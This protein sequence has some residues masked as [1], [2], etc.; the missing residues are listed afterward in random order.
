MKARNGLLLLA[1]LGLALLSGC[2][3]WPMDAGITL[4]SPYYLRHSPQY[5]PPS[6]PY[7]LSKELRSLEE[8]NKKYFDEQ[9]QQ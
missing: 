4:P 1:S 2:Q 6:E 3:T 9:R 7:P 8:A 5:F